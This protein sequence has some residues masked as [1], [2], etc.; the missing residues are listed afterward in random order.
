MYFKALLVIHILSA[1]IGIG[2]SF[3]FGVLGPMSQKLGGPGALAI[4]EGMHAIDRR[5]VNPAVVIQPTS[6][7]LLIFESDRSFFQAEWLWISVVLY[8]AIMILV[9]AFNN[10]AFH[11]MIALAKEGKAETPES[12]GYAK[13]VKALGP[14]I[15]L[16]MVAIIVL[17]VLKPGDAFG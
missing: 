6:G 9:Y 10:P 15:P 12:G 17:M 7:L 13:R 2:P 4:M 16:L 11:K 1:I 3:A 8:A 14:I 5:I